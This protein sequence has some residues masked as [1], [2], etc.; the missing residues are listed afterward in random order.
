MADSTE[1]IAAEIRRQQNARG[2]NVRELEE[3]ISDV[4]DWKHYVSS[5]PLAT[6][7]AAL[8]GGIA[9]GLL[10]SRRWS[11]DVAEDDAQPRAGF[12]SLRG[13]SSLQERTREA[14]DLIQGALLGVGIARLTDFIDS[15]V[16]GFRDHFERTQQQSARFS[17]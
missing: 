2:D 3:K 4:V 5:Y 6:L 12:Q 15:K 17:R 1:Q 13:P 14:V 8:G 9:L 10:T 7:G 16:P 11:L